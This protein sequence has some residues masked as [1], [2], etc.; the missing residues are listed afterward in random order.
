M[1]YF[2]AFTRARLPGLRLGLVRSVESVI[3]PRSI[4]SVGARAYAVALSNDSMYSTTGLK[5]VALDITGPWR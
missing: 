5:P 4:M 1:G 3:P 2:D